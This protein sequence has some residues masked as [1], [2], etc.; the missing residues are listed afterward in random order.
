M[1]HGISTAAIALAASVLFL[2]AAPSAWAEALD[3][4]K[5]AGQVGERP[6]G[7]LGLVS[8]SAP[9]AVKQLVDDVNAKRRAKYAEIAQQNGTAVEAVASL[10]GAKLIERTQAGQYVMGADGR[11]LKK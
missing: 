3:A 6:D 4:A 7:Y 8:P 5:L 1:R 11:W 10:A 2:A 9:A